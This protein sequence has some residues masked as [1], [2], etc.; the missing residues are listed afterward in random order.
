MLVK[1]HHFVPVKM[2]MYV[3]FIS[4]I[5]VLHSPLTTL[6]MQIT[7]DRQSWQG[8][9]T[10]RQ[11]LCPSTQHRGQPGGLFGVMFRQ[12]LLPASFTSVSP[13]TDLVHVLPHI[14]ELNS[15]EGVLGSIMNSGS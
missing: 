6:R 2:V 9:L 5:P 3:N 11:P 8:Q 7:G 4:V 15:T 10:H 13:A 1:G 12:T 14:S